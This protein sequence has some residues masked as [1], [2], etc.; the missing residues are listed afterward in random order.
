MMIP[1]SHPRYESLRQREL[2]VEGYKAG[3]TALEGLIAFGRGEA[4]DYL[5][6]E[7]TPDAAVEAVRAAAAMLLAAENPVVSV[8]GNT[9][10]LCPEELVKLA[11]AV[12]GKL[13]INLF[14]RTEKRVKAIEGILKGHGAEKVYG[15]KADAEIEGLDSRRRLVDREGIYS[16]DV[17]F[18]ALEDG[19]RTEALIKA[20]KK[21]IAVD[22]NPLSRTA[23]TAS[24]TIVDNVIRA[25]PLL[26]AAA[27]ELR[28]MDRE[29]LNRIHR[30]FDNPSNL[31]KSLS[32]IIHGLRSM[33][34]H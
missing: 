21:V 24:I 16:A 18:V 28:A 14:Y 7:K 19:D 1:K 15:V 10:V 17:V 29:A 23:Q 33:A 31:R 25:V 20:G 11:R 26:L 9:A 32:E 4:F 2:L 8:N 22:L 34:S 5:L 13:E 27:E 6:G 3:A 30:S 12:E